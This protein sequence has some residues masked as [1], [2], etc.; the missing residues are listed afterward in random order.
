VPVQPLA[1]LV[2]TPLLRR[3]L[4]ALIGLAALSS[5][6]RRPIGAPLPP[7]TTCRNAAIGLGPRD[8]ITVTVFNEANL[9]GDYRV[10]EDGSLT[11]PYLGRVNVAGMQAGELSTMFHDRLGERSASNPQGGNILRDP[12]V[13]VEVREINSRRI[14]IFGQVQHPGV[15]PHQQCITLTQAISLA[16]GFTALAEKNSVR[17]TRITH[18]ADGGADH[19][20]TFVLRAEDIAEGRA[21][22]FDLLPDDVIFVTESLT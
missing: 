20:Q 1:K 4:F 12:T 5:G 11:F 9:T 7:R 22:D 10:G 21:P 6:C 15:F 13:R 19:R 16:G 8:V 18:D 3:F 2:M 17:V 14:S